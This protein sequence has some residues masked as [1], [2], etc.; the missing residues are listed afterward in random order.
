[1]V[2][3]AIT[4]LL[5]SVFLIESIFA[6]VELSDI[7]QLPQLWSHFEKHKLESPEITFLDFL[8][9]HYG[10]SNHFDQDAGTHKKLP[11][12]SYHF[13]HL[14]FQAMHDRFSIDHSFCY[15]FLM[16]IEGVTYFENHKYS[17]ARSIWQPPKA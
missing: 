11:F 8:Y 4:I 9:L 7:S 1:M 6:G 15:Q 10:D 2:N 13:H 14:T 5:C 17:I 12:T 16:V 3:R